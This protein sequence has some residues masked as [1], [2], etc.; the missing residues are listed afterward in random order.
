MRAMLLLIF[1]AVLLQGCTYRAWF[2]GFVAGQKY[3]CDKLSGA[4]RERCLEA[5][6]DNYERYQRER[7][8][9][10]ERSR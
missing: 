4:E 3:Q 6:V 7:Q 10:L 5:I 8:E 1:A 9:V 2:E